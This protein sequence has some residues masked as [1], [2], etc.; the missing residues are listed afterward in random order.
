MA[1]CRAGA[2]AELLLI[3]RLTAREGHVIRILQ[4]PWRTSPLAL[5]A[6]H[7]ADLVGL[8]LRMGPMIASNLHLRINWSRDRG[9]QPQEFPR[10]VLVLVVV[11]ALVNVS[12]TVLMAGSWAS[13]TTGM[14]ALE[15]SIQ[16]RP[17]ETVN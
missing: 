14:L 10:L 9:R 1:I 13:I 15:R 7:T 16:D 17:T 6:H 5:Q 3:M 12:A 8:P 11:L 2:N 4:V